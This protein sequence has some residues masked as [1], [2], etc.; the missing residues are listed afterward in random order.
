MKRLS[1]RAFTRA[2][3]LELAIIL[4]GAWFA[5]AAIPWSLGGIGISWDALNHH[6]Y[7]GWTAESPRFSRDLKAAASQSYQY[8]YLYWP[9]FKL[10]MADVSGV[11]AGVA[12]AT[13]HWL[14]V[15]AMWMIAR[16]WVSGT[17][18]YERAMRALAIALAFLSPVVLS[19]FDSTSNDLLAA[20]PFIWALAFAL[21]PGGAEGF[22]FPVV[23][24]ASGLL[25]GV[26]VAFKLSNGPL[27]VLL[28]LVWLCVRSAN[29][30]PVARVMVGSAATFAGF[31]LTYV[32][33][34][35]LLWTHLGNPVYPL[36]DS[37]FEPL[38]IWTGWT[39]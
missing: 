31:F 19:L 14:A 13:L 28:P 37:C 36:C 17:G 10:A 27:A 20:L 23:L 6:I 22:R 9:V 8:P 39:R 29:L 16:Q 24:V 3:L 18:I 32:P 38:R 11:T 33:W 5:M 4:I 15:P 12:L 35:W 1:G 21:Q 2:D 30:G 26:A 34:G 25:N 7:L